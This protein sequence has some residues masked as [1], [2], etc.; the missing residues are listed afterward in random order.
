MC[1]GREGGK[2]L[3]LSL[4]FAVNLNSSKKI[5]LK[6]SPLSPAKKS[7]VATSPWLH[8]SQVFAKVKEASGVMGCVVSPDLKFIC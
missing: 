6:M 5:D 3:Y 7:K 8:S 2:S 1:G 4:N